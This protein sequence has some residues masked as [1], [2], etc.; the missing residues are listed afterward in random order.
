MTAEHVVP[1]IHGPD[2]APGGPDPIPGGVAVFEIKVFEDTVPV[3]AGDGA[4]IFEVWRRRR[5]HS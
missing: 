5:S 4:F 3:L 1:V 2:H